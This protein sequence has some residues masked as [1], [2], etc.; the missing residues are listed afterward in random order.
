[1]SITN[2]FRTRCAPSL[3]VTALLTLFPGFGG[4]LAASTD[5]AS[6]PLIT[7][8]EVRAKPNIMFILD[9]SGSMASEYMPDDMS[10]SARYGYWSSQCNGLAYNPNITYSPPVDASG[11]AYSNSSFTSAWDDGY[12]TS[13][14]TTNLA[15]GTFRMTIDTSSAVSTGTGSKTFIISS[16]TESLTSSTFATGG[17]IKLTYYTGGRSGSTYTM[18]GVVSTWTQSSSS[19]GTLVVTVASSSGSGSSSN[20]DIYSAPS[21]Y[22]YS[23]SQ[24]AMGWTYTGSSGTVVTDTDFYKECKSY[25]GDTPGSNVFGKV[26]VTSS[27]AEATNYANWYSYYRTRLLLMR[28]AAGRAFSALDSGYRVGFTTIKD[29]SAVDGTNYFRDVKT[30][31][32]TQK[33]NFY[34]SLYGVDSGSYTPLRA[35]LSKVG[36]YYAKQISGQT[37][38]PMEYACQRN[39]AILS[40]DG[41]WNTDIETTTFGPLKLDG[42]TTVG[43]QDGTEVRPMLDGTAAAVT[44][45]TPTTTIVR[46]QTVTV[47]TTPT[48]Q[49]SR[50][51][52][53]FSSIR[54]NG[55][56]RYRVNAQS[57]TESSVETTTVV[58]ET[59]TV[60]TR[61][62]VTVNGTVT[63]DGS[64]VTSSNTNQISSATSTTTNAGTW[65]DTGNSSNV[66]ISA[67]LNI[68]TGTYYSASCSSSFTTAAAKTACGFS[69]DSNAV[70]GTSTTINRPTTTTNTTTSTLSSVSTVGNST[71][72]DST[73]GGSSDSLADVAE[74]YY[75]TD[76]RTSALGNCTSTTSGSSQDVCAN[77]VPTSGRDIKTSQHMTTYTIGLGVSGTL[78]Y[79]KNYLT[80]TS[81]SYVDL[82]K[83]NADWP[84]P[85]DGKE[86]VNIDDLW[87][88][89]VDGRGQYYSALNAT[90]LA[91]A[92]SGV[93]NSIMETTGS[94]SAATTSTLELVSGDNNMV[95][96]GR[97]TTSTWIGDIK[98]YTM[99]GSTGAIATTASWS[100]QSL[101]DAVVPSDRKIYFNKSG[102]LTSFE[103][104]NLTS[105]QKAYFD[106]LCTQTLV[107]SQCASFSTA[108]LALANSGAYLV[109]YLRGVR[110]YE[111]S[112]TTN[113]LFR[114]RSH[115]LGDIINSTPVYVGAPLF[116][117]A[118]SG[119][120][121]FKAAQDSRTKIV[122][123][124][125]NDGMLHA[126]NATTGAEVWSFVPSAVMS[127][128]YKLANTNYAGNHVYFV[129]GEVVVGDIYVNS[130]WKTILVGGFNS[131]GKGYY[132]LDITTPESPKVLWE[133]S[134][135]S[136]LGLSFGNPI[137]TKRADGTWVVVFTS[138]YN[139]TTGDG[140]GHLYVLD[141]NA[142]T[143]VL[144]IATGVGSSGAPSGLA[145]INAWIEDATDNTALRFYGGDLLGNL[146]RFDIDNLVEPKQ[147]AMLL[148]KFQTSGALVQPI[149]VKPRLKSIS[150]YPVV[151]V[152]TGRYL[153]TSDIADT[154]TQ[155][156]AAVKDS[157][158]DTGW[159]VIRNNSTMV[160]QTLTVS[161]S[162]VT[163]TA[164][165]VDWATKNGWWFD[166]PNT[167]ERVVVTPAIYSNTLYLAT[168]IPKGDACTSGGASWLYKVSLLDGTTTGELYSSTEMI[169]GLTVV[170]LAASS[171]SGSETGSQEIGIVIQKSNGEMK[172]NT[173]TGGSSGGSVS[174][175][176]TSWRELAN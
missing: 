74:Y 95:Y 174:A 119:Y 5:L 16:S 34:S 69:S 143:K 8:Q 130:A 122:Y 43:N 148:G 142:G 105:A 40:T 47:K 144:D 59:T 117:Y 94:G 51:T 97:Y 52:W 152:G 96:Q 73:V 55:N 35:A 75:V 45:T 169:S 3:A 38:D 157:L 71:S 54:S 36:R 121:A 67:A 167:G 173:D 22:T 128:M 11:T 112:N 109:D 2:Y 159:G 86:A 30:F 82:T 10:N 172:V 46:N 48:K 21:Y 12:D 137:I 165:V 57:R 127:N 124:G 66:D 32:S 149:T 19:T 15:T 101:L 85:G 136:N 89:A 20:W 90:E 26:Y 76:L 28:T 107:A 41:Y 24:P 92:I 131:G 138:G 103:Y 156:F 50:Y 114:T 17:A 99:N 65:S 155:S 81:G 176:R 33:T 133:F 163:S 14:S 139:N 70:S 170:E 4:A 134:T 100:A 104:A 108:N 115:V 58:T 72:T 87:H 29:K 6:E 146:W 145:K 84:V 18:T 56:Y 63:S 9:S 31:D 62:V 150:G 129:D 132:A 102:T 160:Q 141:A 60:T 125:A 79:D 118:D 162:S 78:T 13:G 164:N 27:S 64:S 110:T 1:M 126:F 37:Y 175:R 44:T 25:I 93:V 83:G 106:N 161:G 168:A 7:M 147:K 91:N 158:T 53:P 23:G 88:A 116:S 77:I 61:V 80:Q 166:L 140:D 49:Y 120:A 39:F 68:G 42:A 98:A 135:D 171:S 111:A 113:P 151:A 123:A 154:T 153:G